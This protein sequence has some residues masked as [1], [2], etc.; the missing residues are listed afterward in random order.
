MT[1]RRT[2]RVRYALSEESE[3][4]KVAIA[5]PV[6]KWSKRWSKPPLSENDP[7]KKTKYKV[8]KWEK[9][10]QKAEFEPESELELDGE[11]ESEM[12]TSNQPESDMPTENQ[13]ESGIP[14][15]NQPESEMPVENQP[16]QK[17]ESSIM[18]ETNPDGERTISEETSI[19]EQVNQEQETKNLENTNL[20]ETKQDTENTD[21]QELEQV[22]TGNETEQIIV[23]PESKST[24]ETNDETKENPFGINDQQPNPDI[25]KQ[26]SQLENSE[27]L[28]C[29]EILVADTLQNMTELNET[30]L[31]KVKETGLDNVEETA[32]KNVLGDEQL[33]GGANTHNSQQNQEHQQLDPM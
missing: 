19:P 8:Y 31:E 20:E 2:N 30:R 14:T 5:E 28:A 3:R 33:K 16:E 12:P 18:E 11:Q 4:L 27:N 17:Q 23:N 1:T 29:D 32:P 13:P 10:E 9:T 15:E 22:S 24:C 7:R 25:E 6:F 26:N 21:L